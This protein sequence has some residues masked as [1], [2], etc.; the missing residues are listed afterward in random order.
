MPTLMLLNPTA[1]LSD[2][3]LDEYTVLDCE[4]L[5][6][7]KGHLIHLCMSEI[8]Y[9]PD[10]YRTQRRV[11]QLYNCSWVHH[12]L[13]KSLFTKVHAGMTKDK[14][15]G[16][17][18]HALVAHAPLQYEVISLHSVNTENQERIFS[19]ARKTAT[20]RLPLTDIHRTLYRLWS[21]DFKLK[22]SSKV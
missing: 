14:M 15:F 16:N 6:D 21:F 7:L 5:H 17:Y 4:P 20:A 18:L 2:L 3:N 1:A 12:E 11:L 13:C 8:L 9:L 22:H 10:A 19:Q